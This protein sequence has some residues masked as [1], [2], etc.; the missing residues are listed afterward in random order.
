MS[1][2]PF[3]IQRV[4]DNANC[5]IHLENYKG[6]ISNVDAGFVSVLDTSEN[7]LFSQVKTRFWEVQNHGWI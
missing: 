1:Y 7:L 4:S 2:N 5:K 6:K 3:N